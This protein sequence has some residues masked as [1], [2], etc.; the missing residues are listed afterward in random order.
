MTDPALSFPDQPRVNLDSRLADLVS[1]AN[2]VLATQGRLRALLRANQAIT[3]QLDLD[4]VLR[5]VV[6][7]ARDLTG[8]EYA[9]L[10]VLDGHGGLEQ[11]IHVGMDP[12]A[13]AR[14]GHLPHGTGLLG[15][16][17]TDPESIRIPEIATDRRSAGFPAG[18]PP[19][20][21]FLGVPVRIRGVVYGNL[22]LTNHPAGEF[23]EEDEQL[24][25][26]LAATAG[27]AVENARLYQETQRREQWA[28]ASAE[29]T[30]G[31]LTKR[32][33]DAL[34][35][36]AERVH[37]LATADSVLV[38]LLDEEGLRLSV[39]AV[40]GTDPVSRSS[41][42]VPLAGSLVERVLQSGA[43]SRFEERA[44]REL[45]VASA[46]SSGP[47]M[48]LPLGTTDRV[49]GAIVVVRRPRDR[50]FTAAELAVAADFAARTSVALELYRARRDQ[51]QVL[52]FEDRGR[53]ARDLHD[54]VI[55]QLFATGMQLQGVLGTL[56]DGRNA[57][58]V[59]AAI[60]TLDAS[61]AQIRRII[62][63]L[64]STRSTG[65][66]ATARHR[67][68]DLV[69]DLASSLSVE[70]HIAFT[71]PV[72][73]VLDGEVTDD[74]LAVVSEG[75]ANAVKHGGATD[76]AVG[77]SADPAGI[78]V[79][80]SNDGLPLAD[81]GRRS[82]LRNLEERARRRGGEMRLVTVEDRTVMTWRVP[83]LRAGRAAAV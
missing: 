32:H 26:S 50:A 82:G 22:Y 65:P 13:V 35:L 74:V 77:I 62:F 33:E 55:Q 21:D 11:F 12:G 23:S 43:P 18:H 36:V 9:A 68:L 52:L 30:A 53:I 48:A 75:V 5:S 66:D 45:G 46:A 73:A 39:V 80:V 81:S 44:V 51:E 31:L 3:A 29:A 61:I 8:A 6:D 47:M 27:F 20:K 58:R 69:G 56:P 59:D 16:L 28:A 63:T 79:T 49:L 1:A 72:D 78:T 24:V 67:L 19:M 40:E 4:S 64:S 10:G 34:A 71:G 41:T 54:R 17:I 57:E 60:T 38:A 2:E 76:I 42:D 15:A 25:R 14:I 37:T 70:P 7:A 83:P